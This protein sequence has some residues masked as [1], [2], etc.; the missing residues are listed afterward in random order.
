LNL[1]GLLNIGQML[2]SSLATMQLRHPAADAFLSGVLAVAIASPCTA[3]FMGA[4]LG[5]A[6]ALPAAQALTLFAALGIG[7]ALP[8]LLASWFPG[9]T[10]W[11]PRPGAWMETLRR[12]MAFPMW[13]TVVWLLWVLGHLSGVDGAASLAAILLAVALLAWSAS[14]RGHSQSVLL[15]VSGATLVA[16]VWATGANVLKLE[17]SAAPATNATG[18]TNAGSWQAWVPGRVEAE[19]ATGKPVFVDFTAAWCITC[20]Y[21]KKT[22]LSDADVVAD[23][24]AKKVQLLRADWTR[25][26][27]AIT[28]ALTELGRSGVPVYVLYQPGQPPVVFSEILSQSELRAALAKLI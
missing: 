22:T 25:R 21:N 26:D 1:M 9:L 20:Q 17:E 11:L 27:P 10:R 19:L 2:P 5:Y 4:S 13:A 15:A 28:R 14:Q 18:T 8:Y 24:A 7:L 6:I 23:F 3:P 12:F 16:L